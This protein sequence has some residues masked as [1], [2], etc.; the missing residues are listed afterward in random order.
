[1]QDIHSLNHL[2]SQS[3]IDLIAN[4]ECELE[5]DYL[6]YMLL[7]IKLKKDI[8]NLGFTPEDDY[9]IWMLRI[10]NDY[11]TTPKLIT[12]APLYSICILLSEVFKEDKLDK[13]K[14]KLP[15]TILKQLLTRLNEFKLH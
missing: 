2:P 3:A 5:T 4:Y 14:E 1:M 10:G 12:H 9:Q 15:A 8:H 6:D 13:L 7:L 11:L